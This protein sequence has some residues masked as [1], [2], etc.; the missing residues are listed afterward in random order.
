M[1]ESI[2]DILRRHIK[3]NQ[4]LAKELGGAISEHKDDSAKP[5]VEAEERHVN[6]KT[7]K[8]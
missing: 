7:V 5:A 2:N 3:E 8:N 4:E 1:Q 6:E